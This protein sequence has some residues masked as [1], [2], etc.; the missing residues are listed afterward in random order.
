VAARRRAAMIGRQR[1]LVLVSGPD[2]ASYLQGLLTN[3]IVALKPGEGCYSAYL[4][5]QGRMISDMSVHELGDVILLVL[6]VATKDTVLARLDQFLF[7]EDVQLGDVSSTLA[8]LMIAGPEAAPLLAAAMDT[9]PGQL[10]ALP[11]NGIVRISRGEEVL[12]VRRAADVGGFALEVLAEAGAVSGI[13]QR[14]RD[15]GVEALTPDAV[16]LLRIEAGMP[17]FGRELEEDTIPLEAVIEV[18]AI[19]FTK[20]CY[21]G[22]EVIIRVLH[23]GHGR[24]ARRLVGLLFDRQTEAPPAGT[25]LRSGDKE[26]GSITSSA[27]SPVLERPVALGYV[28]RDFA[29]AG[30]RVSTADGVA[31]EVTTLPFVSA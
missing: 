4:T 2:R 20:G 29:A 8:A 31:A 25:L 27:F 24:V 9:G 23:R 16:E 5:P 19:S 22:Q 17:L 6:P 14:L 15:Q 30:T 21:V 3:D 18:R 26:L 13:E 7:S 28:K 12:L 1:G 10:E 11:P